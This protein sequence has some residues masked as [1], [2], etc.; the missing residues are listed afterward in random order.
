MAF[1][2]LLIVSFAIDGGVKMI[3]LGKIIGFNRAT[4]FIMLYICF[5]VVFRLFL[6]EILA[7]D[8][9]ASMA[10]YLQF[11]ILRPTLRCHSN[12]LTLFVLL[13]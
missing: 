9:H 5:S 1:K 7:I 8:S 10:G 6:N 11:E 12:Y 13:F 2:F 3:F 4:A